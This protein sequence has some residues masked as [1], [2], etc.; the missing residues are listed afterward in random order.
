MAF[1]WDLN[2]GSLT[3]EIECATAALYCCLQGKQE[4]GKRNKRQRS[5]TFEVYRLRQ[6]SVL[7]RSEFKI[8][9]LS[10]KIRSPTSA[11]SSWIFL[12][13][14]FLISKMGIKLFLR[15]FPGGSVV[16]NPPSNEGDAGSTCGW[17][18]KIPH[19]TEQLSPC[20]STSELALRGLWART[21][22]A[23]FCS[24]WSLHAL[25]SVLCNKR[26]HCNERPSHH[27]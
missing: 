2:I 26:S 16:K 10:L 14:S 1:S 22:E 3:P 8:K 19:T 11:S 27:N 25:E 7:I 21:T 23:T 13:L 5:N 6:H 9:V 24:Y 12:D 15:G 17:G 18:T 4:R 20:T